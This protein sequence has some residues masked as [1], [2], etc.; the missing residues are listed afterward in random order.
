MLAVV[1]TPHT[2]LCIKGEI[3]KAVL[4]VLKKSFGDKLKIKEDEYVNAFETEWYKNT[5]NE[6]TVGDTIKAYRELMGI[7][8]DQLGQRI[9]G[10]SRHF[11]SD[12]ERSRRLPSKEIAKKLSKVFMVTTDHFL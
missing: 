7:T 4:S 3:P 11:I 5:D 8:Q 12:L 1:K 10:Q 9:G 6:M 2:D